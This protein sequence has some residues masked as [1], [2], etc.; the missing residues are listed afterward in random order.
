MSEPKY[1]YPRN[2]AGTPKNLTNL[3][4]AKVVILPVPYDST[5]TYKSGAS[6][7][8]S[9]IISAS[10]YSELDRDIYKVGMHTLD[11]LVVDVSAS[12]KMFTKLAKVVTKYAKMKKIVVTLGGD[13]SLAAGPAYAFSKIYKDLSVLYFDA[14]LDLREE[15]EGAAFG[16]A[17]WARRVWEFG[18]PVIPVG[19]R[20]LSLDEKEFVKNKKVPVYFAEDIIKNPKLTSDISS[21]LTKNIYISFDVDALDP[22]IM[23]ATGTPEP[24]GLDWYQALDILKT[25]TK[26]RNVVGFDICELSPSWGPHSCSFTAAKLVY[27]IIGYIT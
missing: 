17:T 24:G 4:S 10:E 11:E 21:K 19:I 26:G 25:A 18:I 27:K 15:Y 22:S 9:A 3:K 6:D 5:T 12:K 2:F 23:S 14:H 7:G 16:S 1:F 8:P 20:S 13:H